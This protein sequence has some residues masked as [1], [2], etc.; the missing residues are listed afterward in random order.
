MEETPLCS[1][2][3]SNVAAKSWSAQKHWQLQVNIK[4]LSSNGYSSIRF[5]LR[6]GKSIKK[7]LTLF[8]VTRYF[9]LFLASKKFVSASTRYFLSIPK[10]WDYRLLVVSVHMYQILLSVCHS[11]AFLELAS[12]HYKAT[13]CLVAYTR[14]MPWTQPFFTFF[15]QLLLRWQVMIGVTLQLQHCFHMKTRLTLYTNHNMP[16]R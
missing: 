10:F 6:G 9:P 3:K 2:R 15:F 12:M 14:P 8:R 13:V 7:P 4:K 16:L 11:T 1:Q 5:S